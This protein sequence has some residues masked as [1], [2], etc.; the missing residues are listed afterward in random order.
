MNF[1]EYQEATNSTAVYPEGY[2]I[3][4]IAYCALGLTGEAGE[5]ANKV[6]KILR[7]DHE[8]ATPQI[9]EAIRKELGDVLWYLAQLTE[10]LGFELDTIAQENIDKLQSRKERGVIQGSGDNR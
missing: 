6:K 2:K 5:I 4:G 7:G 9:R 3:G 10:N 8:L 1:R